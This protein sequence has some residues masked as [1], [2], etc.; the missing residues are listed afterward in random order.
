MT[1]CVKP[2]RL[3]SAPP[4]APSAGGCCWAPWGDRDPLPSYRYC[5][6]PSPWGRGWGRG[7]DSACPPLLPSIRPEPCRQGN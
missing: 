2:G 1:A 7:K 5:G 4:P 6:V 3:P